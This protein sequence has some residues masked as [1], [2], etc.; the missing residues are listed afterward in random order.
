[1]GEPAP[2]F[3]ALLPALNWPLV[4]LL[5]VGAA[6][7]LLGSH[8]RRQRQLDM[9][10]SGKRVPRQLR[11]ELWYKRYTRRQAAQRKEEKS[12]GARA[13]ASK[14]RQRFT[15]RATLEKALSH[16]LRVVIDCSYATVHTLQV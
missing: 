14:P 9:S 3:Y 5:C 10:G 4:L 6:V 7:V 13:A 1:M 15:D 16:P 11:N 2:F 12:K 8:D